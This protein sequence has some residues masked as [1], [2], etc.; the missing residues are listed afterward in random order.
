MAL[1]LFDHRLVGVEDK[2]DADALA[3]E[4]TRP[5]D[6]VQVVFFQRRK[7]IVDDNR[8]LLNIDAACKKVGCDEDAGGAG[9]EGAHNVIPFL[10]VHFAVHRADGKVAVLHL[11]GKLVD[12]ATGVAEDDGLGDG[13]G[14]VQIAQR[15]E[16]VL[17]LADIDEELLDA[18]Q[19]ELVSLH[20]DADGLAHKVISNLDDFLLDRCRDQ[21]HL[22]AVG[23]ALEDFIYLVLEAAAEHF[24]GLVQDEHLDVRGAKGLAIDHVKDAPGSAD[25]NVHTGLEAGNVFTNA[26]STDTCVAA[27]IQFLAKRQDDA[28]DLL[29]KLTRRGQHQGLAFLQFIVDLL[30]D[31]NCKGC[32]LSCSRLCLRNDI[33]LGQDGNDGACL[34]RRRLFEPAQI[35]VVT[36]RVSL[37]P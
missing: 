35:K 2:V 36:N 1:D 9:A 31:S 19:G 10:L 34:D 8:N 7:V 5:T 15:L 27:D 13:D 22:D 24:V 17:L 37:Y 20:E 18:F 16:L 32:S 3:A 30:Q 23:K 11:V 21:D 12:L 25:N 4:A 29:G 28:L 33:A 26:C 6:A 14:V